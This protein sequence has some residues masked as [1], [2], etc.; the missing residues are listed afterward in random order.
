MN[1]YC[2]IHNS[3]FGSLLP[4]INHKPECYSTHG[5]DEYTFSHFVSGI[6]LK[7]FFPQIPGI[8]LFIIH[9]VWELIETTESFQK[10]Q[11]K[12]Y[13]ITNF[14]AVEYNGDSIIN[15]YVDNIAFI[16]GLLIV[17]KKVIDNSITNK[18][19]SIIVFII[20]LVIAIITTY[21]IYPSQLLITNSKSN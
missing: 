11:N 6:I 21:R 9:L 16:L 12:I 10:I 14:S 15:S 7:L 4:P 13:D 17:K 20:S 19:Y 5:I 18:I 1:L 8:N 3:F 2:K